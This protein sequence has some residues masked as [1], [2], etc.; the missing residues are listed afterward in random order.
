MSRRRQ[1]IDFALRYLKSNLDE[2]FEYDDLSVT[3][4]TEEELDR[5]IAD[6]ETLQQRDEQGDPTRL[7]L[8]CVDTFL[9]HCS[10]DD[11]DINRTLRLRCDLSRLADTPKVAAETTNP[12]TEPFVMYDAKPCRYAE[13]GIERCDKAE[14][15]FW[16]VYG[17]TNAGLSQAIGDFSTE[18][19]A[20]AICKNLCNPTL[21]LRDRDER[22]HLVT[23]TPN[24]RDG[25]LEL[26]TSVKVSSNGLTLSFDAFPNQP[27]EYF[28]MR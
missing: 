19:F 13:D 24:D 3:R 21:R 16:T 27:V 22:V 20:G 18:E 9:V 12:P 17:V 8:Q 5:L 11:P 1:L 25:T 28:I 14:A 10:Q 23:I 2:A 6:F 26:N 4:P 15:E 7:L